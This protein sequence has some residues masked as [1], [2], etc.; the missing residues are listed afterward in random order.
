MSNFINKSDFF[1]AITGQAV[2]WD[3]PGI[4]KIK[5]RGLTMQE[6]NETRNRPNTDVVTSMLQ[7]IQLCM[8]EPPLSADDIAQL[9]QAAPGKLQ[10]IGDK[11]A[12]LS[13]IKDDKAAVEDLEKK[14]GNGS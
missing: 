3:A 2:E 12:I 8:V 10:P 14:A 11:I 5:L 13:G 9:W 6:F 7:W 4:G 1:A